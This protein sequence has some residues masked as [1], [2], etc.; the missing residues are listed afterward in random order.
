[1]LRRTFL[2]IPGFGPTRERKLWESGV[3]DW[4]DLRARVPLLIAD[5][6]RAGET[7]RVL[8]ESEEA[9]SKGDLGFFYRLLPRDELWRLL[10][11]APRERIAYLDIETTG[12]GMPPLSRSTVIA[13]W[14]GGRLYQAH[15]PS[16]KRKL[17][18][19]VFSEASLVCTFFGEV[20][21]VPFLR[22]EFDLPLERAHIDL[23]F[24]LKRLGYKG[25]LKRVEK[26]FP[27][28]SR[29]AMDIDGFDAVRLWKMHQRGVQG[30]L[31]TLY[32]YNAEDTVVLE[33]LLHH[34]WNLEVQ[35][36]PELGLKSWT[37]PGVPGLKTRVHREVYEAL[38][39][40]AP[41][42]A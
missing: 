28:Q 14:Y 30:A 8:D 35:R 33:A 1:V 36:R 7:L 27:I 12:T 38:R 10:N 24:W 11:G 23:C 16:R 31:E 22:R 37:V 13:V 19:E 41:T 25:G 2:H 3:L 6:A 20:F 18:Q 4:Q 42:Q 39:A 40:S 17:L 29:S 5:A 32:T 15:E 9:H 21:D 34:A 26:M